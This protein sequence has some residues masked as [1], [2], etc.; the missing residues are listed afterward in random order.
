M[1][2]RVRVTSSSA[3]LVCGRRLV[4]PPQW[5]PPPEPPPEAAAGP[6]VGP[7]ADAA[8]LSISALGSTRQKVQQSNAK[9][10]KLIEHFKATP[11][12]QQTI[13]S[14]GIYLLA[15]LVVA[16]VVVLLFYLPAKLKALRWRLNFRSS[17]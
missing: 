7:P 8:W 15:L 3:P 14:T 17:I 10:S 12:A 2:R 1:A 6:P 16:V 11:V 5:R 4:G 13:I 9:Q